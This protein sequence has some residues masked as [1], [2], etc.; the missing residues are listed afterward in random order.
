MAKD[1]Q[2]QTTNSTSDDS[3]TGHQAPQ[4]KAHTQPKQT[5]PGQGENA[6]DLLRGSVAN[7]LDS[8]VREYEPQIA[9]FMSSVAHQAGE[10]GVSFAHATVQ[11]LRKQSWVRLAVAA[12]LGVGAIAVLSYE[13]GETAGSP[14]K[15]RGQRTPA[16]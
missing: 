6:L 5:S 15:N 7:V 12:A 10:R 16:H 9:E 2:N 13:A 14:A 1:S 11:G 8:V 3:M 4:A